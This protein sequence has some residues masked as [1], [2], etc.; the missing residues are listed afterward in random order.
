MTTYTLPD[1]I[2][3][4]A[5]L[6]TGASVNSTDIVGLMTPAGWDAAVITLQAGIDGVNWQEMVD[7][8]GNALTIQ[9]TAARYFALP[10]SMLPGVG[11][12]RIRSGTLA[13]PVNQTATRALVWFS[14]NYGR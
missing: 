11:W 3:S 4:G 10:P 9:A 14:R 2:A 12:I 6:S 8:Y 7:Q 13:A 1:S 5:A